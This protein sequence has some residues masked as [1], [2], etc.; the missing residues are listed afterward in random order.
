MRYKLIIFDLDGT[1]LDTLSDHQRAVNYIM[2]KY[3]YQK[4]NQEAVR[5]VLGNGL[6]NTISKLLPPNAIYEN[7]HIIEEFV[8]F[9]QENANIDTKPYPDILKMLKALKRDGYTLCLCSNKR[10]NVVDEL[11]KIYF[12]DLFTLIIGEN[13]AKGIKKKP[14]PDMVCKL[15][16]NLHIQK[17]KALYVGDSEVDYYTSIAANIDC[18]LVSWG[19]RDKSF[20]KE[21]SNNVIDLPMDIFDVL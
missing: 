21:L 16:D 4:V 1:L 5:K 18:L 12:S 10:Y 8:S 14:S 9:Y 7:P 13:E 2:K 6:V 11:S 17:D 20:L 15:I 3:N 19:F